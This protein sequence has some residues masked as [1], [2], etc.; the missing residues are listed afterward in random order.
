M[1]PLGLSELASLLVKTPAAEVWRAVGQLVILSWFYFMI[2][3]MMTL[4]RIEG[5][6]V[7]LVLFSHGSPGSILLALE[8]RMNISYLIPVCQN[9]LHI[10]YT[11][12]LAL[13]V[14]ISNLINTMTP[15]KFSTSC[16]IFTRYGGLVLDSD[17]LV[18]D[19]LLA[20]NGSF[21]AMQ[22]KLWHGNYD[23]KKIIIIN[24]KQ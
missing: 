24:H 13:E 21:V 14:R 3:M 11:W 17:F 23:G 20:I 22:V 4:I 10:T 8:V 12:L 18:L 6:R 19:S 1:I 9:I 15:W 5:E 7:V 16:H 2:T